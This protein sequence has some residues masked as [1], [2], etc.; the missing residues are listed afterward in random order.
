MRIGLVKH[1]VGLV[2]SVKPENQEA[3]EGVLSIEHQLLG[4]VNSGS[5]TVDNQDL[6]NVS[7]F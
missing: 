5:I 4:K 1:K 7:D 2:V 6:G 3:F